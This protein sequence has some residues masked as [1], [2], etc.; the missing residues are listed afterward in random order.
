M[1]CPKCGGFLQRDGSRYQGDERF[2]CI[3]G[4]SFWWGSKE[5]G[6]LSG[7]QRRTERG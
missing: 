4:H 5:Y 7:E 3:G 2:L 6:A 1:R